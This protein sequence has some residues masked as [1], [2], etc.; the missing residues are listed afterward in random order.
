MHGFWAEQSNRSD[1]PHSVPGTG[2]ELLHA[3]I[4]LS[5]LVEECQ[6]EKWAGHGLYET[7]FDLRD[8]SMKCLGPTRV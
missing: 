8:L 3:V 2:P 4:S 7:Q 1:V 6:A 5:A